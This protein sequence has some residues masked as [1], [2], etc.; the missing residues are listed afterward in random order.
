[1]NRQL[2]AHKVFKP[3]EYWICCVCGVGGGGGGVEH[4]WDMIMPNF[5]LRAYGMSFRA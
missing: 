5:E 4:Y 3:E 1:M 2:S